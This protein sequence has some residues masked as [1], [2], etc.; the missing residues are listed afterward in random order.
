M[1]TAAG[2]T[3]VGRKRKNNEDC[4]APVALGGANAPQLPEAA[5]EGPLAEPGVL[6]VV[7]DGMGGAEAGEVASRLAVETVVTELRAKA[8]SSAD[9]AA[10]LAGSGGGTPRRHPHHSPTSTRSGHHWA[11]RSSRKRHRRASAPWFPT[12]HLPNRDGATRSRIFER[13]TD[14]QHPK[15]TTR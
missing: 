8:A 10:I 13:R 2:H 12:L 5:L 7:A 15:N 6:L 4:F 14:R 11:K 9:M 3:D 1:L